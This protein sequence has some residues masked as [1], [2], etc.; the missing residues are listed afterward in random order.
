MLRDSKAKERWACANP[1]ISACSCSISLYQSI[2]MVRYEQQLQRLF[3][4]H[5]FELQCWGSATL[6]RTG[7]HASRN[8]SNSLSGVLNIELIM[9]ECNM[10]HGCIALHM[11]YYASTFLFSIVRPF[12][13]T[14]IIIWLP[15]WCYIFWL[16]L[17]LVD[18]KIVM[19]S[20]SFRIRVNLGNRGTIVVLQRYG[21]ALC[22]LDVLEMVAL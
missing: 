4:S 7:K 9:S 10:V 12:L 1:C 6:G 17:H 20:L 5:S 13:E 3:L 2:C 21:L 22:F 18:I 19:I 11:W 15:A 16:R 8:L 14:I